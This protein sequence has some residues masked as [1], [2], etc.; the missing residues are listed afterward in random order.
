MSVLVHSECATTYARKATASAAR[1]LSPRRL[2]PSC[3]TQPLWRI[4]SKT[5]SKTS[6]ALTDVDLHR[7]RRQLIENSLKAFQN[8]SCSSA[9]SS[10]FLCNAQCI[11]LCNQLLALLTLCFRTSGGHPSARSLAFSPTLP[12]CRCRLKCSLT[13]YFQLSSAAG[14][15]FS[16]GSKQQPAS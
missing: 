16:T 8:S 2:A 11:F 9:L 4:W 10:I 7:L 14:T 3:P 15:A 6:S 13:T 1:F 12:V 5:G